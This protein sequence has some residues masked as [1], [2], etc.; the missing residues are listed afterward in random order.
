MSDVSSNFEPNI[1]TGED[2]I[3]DYINNEKVE[4]SL[5]SNNSV[6]YSNHFENLEIIGILICCI[7]FGC[8]LAISFIKGFNK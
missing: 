7:M 2:Y 6:D 1:E 4:T 3:E 5:Y 8:C